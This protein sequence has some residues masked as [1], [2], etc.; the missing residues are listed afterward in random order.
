MATLARDMVTGLVLAGGRGSRMGGVDRG[1]QML[2][3]VPLVEHA[4]RRLA[5]QVGALMINANR[6]LDTY[7][8]FGFPVCPDADREFAGPL[9]GFVAGLARCAS[10]WLATVP[11]D[12]P[13]F[14]VDLVER[15]LAAVGTASV[16]VACTRE[17]GVTQRQPVFCLLRRTVHADIVAYLAGGGRKIDGWFKQENCVDVLFEDVDAFFNANTL[18]EL[19]RLGPA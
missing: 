3:G 13:R 15:L 16:A 19:R 14:P 18:E 7:A 9:A 10:D 6:N 5:P 11:C 12:T 8:R 4:A 1:L 2:D 17:N